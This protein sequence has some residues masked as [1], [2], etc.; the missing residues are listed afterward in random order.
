MN[1]FTKQSVTVRAPG[2]INIIGD[3][4]DYSNGFVMPA[5]IN[6][7]TTFKLDK[8][9]NGTFCSVYSVDT[10]TTYEFDIKDVKCCNKDSWQKYI[11]AVLVLLKEKGIEILGFNAS[12][13][14]TIPIGSGISSSASL[15]SSFLYGLNCL[16]DLDLELIDMIQLSQKAEHYI[17]VNCGIMDQFVSFNGQRD[18][19]MLLNCGTKEYELFNIDLKD[20]TFLLINSNV[21]H[22]LANS[23]YNIRRDTCERSLHKIQNAINIE[24][25]GELNV[26]DLTII[27][28]V[29]TPFEY[30]RVKHV[31][32]E[33]NRVH[34]VRKAF[35]NSNLTNVGQLMYEGH[36]SLKN[37]YEVSCK[38]IDF[39]VDFCRE[40]DSVLGARMMGGG[41]GGCALLLISKKDITSFSIKLKKLYFKNF[42]FQCSSLQIAIGD[43]AKELTCSYDHNLTSVSS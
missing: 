9:H 29:L 2:R 32:E 18:K 26:S 3:H 12:F 7:D 17:G 42:S 40:N 35:E 41:F 8:S 4:T 38:E 33:N 25:L 6:L 39:I 15:V 27:K 34:L 10:N 23:E 37:N 20:H 36:E 1:T 24:S 21:S 28:N 22:E 13:S 19:A 43:G 14:G 11:D 31:V 30:K 16:F 5:A